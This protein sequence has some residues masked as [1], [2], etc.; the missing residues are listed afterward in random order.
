[1]QWRQTTGHSV[2]HVNDVFVLEDEDGR[3]LAKIEA[4]IN[5]RCRAT[6]KL[7]VGDLYK[8]FGPID[9][10]KMW[11]ENEVLAQSARKPKKQLLASPQEGADRRK[12]IQRRYS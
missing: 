4:D 5:G 11:C 6:I 1:M 10:A 12:R 8:L 3:R 9:S 7:D 2:G